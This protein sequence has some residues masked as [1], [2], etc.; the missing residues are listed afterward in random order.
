MKVIERIKGQFAGLGDSF[1][2]YPITAAL[3]ITLMVILIIQNER[4][5]DGIYETEMLRR[6]AMTAAIGMLSSISLK[7]LQERF[8][9]NRPALILVAVPTA[10]LMGLYFI[11]FT[12]DMNQISTIRF[13][14]FLLILILAL[15]YTLKLKQSR[16]YEPYVI[17]IFNGFF[18]TVLY[19]GVLYFGISAI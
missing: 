19:S 16:N 4:N 18:I 3:S 11:F 13:I 5:I 8:Q 15:F 1:L 7:H 9:P 6:L 12:E 14:G 17:R 2:R 10:L